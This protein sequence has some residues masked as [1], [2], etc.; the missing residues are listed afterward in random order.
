MPINVTEGIRVLY[1]FVEIQF[2]ISL[3]EALMVE[4]FAITKKLAIIST[5]QFLSAVHVSKGVF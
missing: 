5:V 4:N 1:V 3:L 2:D